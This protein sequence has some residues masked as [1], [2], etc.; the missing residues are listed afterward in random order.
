V[1]HIF[2]DADDTDPWTRVVAGV[3]PHPLVDRVGVRPV[4]VRHVAVDD[5]D[6]LRLTV[7]GGCERPAAQHRDLH[8]LE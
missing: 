4:T 5:D 1:P 6:R 8:R 2:G 3:Q 7:V